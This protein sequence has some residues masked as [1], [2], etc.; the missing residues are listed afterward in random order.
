VLATK[1]GRYGDDE[2]DF[3]AARVTRS[4]RESIERL[5]VGHI[6]LRYAPCRKPCSS[7]G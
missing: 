7:A 6:D 2:F 4:V 1:V 3:S 5:G